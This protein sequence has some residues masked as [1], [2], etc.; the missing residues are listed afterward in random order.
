MSSHTPPYDI[1][2][3][4]AELKING[5]VVFEDIIPVE[6]VDR[7]LA[8]FMPLLEG[9]REREFEIG[10]PERGDVRAGKGRLQNPNRYTMHVP[11]VM[12]F[13]DPT[14]YEHPVILEFFTR[15][16]GTDDFFITCYHSN[17][18][19]PGTGYQRW[20]RDIQL[21]TPQMGLPVCPHFGLKIP[22]VDTSEENGSIEVLPGTQYL[23]DPD[24]ETRYDEILLRGD[25]P[26]ARRLNL[27][28]GSMW[29]QDPRTLHRGT[30]NRSDGP[31][32][33]VVLCYSRSWF[34]VRHPLIIEHEERSR[35][36]E[37]GIR[38][39]SRSLQG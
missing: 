2:L 5:Y 12:P 30:P 6:T 1:D 21:L 31:R 17:N 39:L 20:H 38:L 9:V 35:L 37:R 32:P 3:K 10:A 25:F 4:I 13:A 23:A 22:L 27:K 36:S 7:L 19:Y 16:W 28:K 15:Y 8:A 29:I 33:E 26:S 14:I 34:A 24:L 18:P 11:W